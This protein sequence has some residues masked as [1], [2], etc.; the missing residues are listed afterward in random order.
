MN[1]QIMTDLVPVEQTA[2]SVLSAG[3]FDVA[4]YRHHDRH[5]D[6]LLFVGHEPNSVRSAYSG[7]GRPAPECL[8]RGR[9]VDMYV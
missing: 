8:T 1:V 7:E 4:S 9:L 2:L 6:P 5:S 3:R